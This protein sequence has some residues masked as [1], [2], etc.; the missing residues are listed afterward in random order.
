[1]HAFVDRIS[2]IQKRDTSDSEKLWLHIRLC[3]DIHWD[4]KRAA[5]TFMHIYSNRFAW[6]FYV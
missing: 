6:V 4:G 5:V 2:A 1:M 3:S